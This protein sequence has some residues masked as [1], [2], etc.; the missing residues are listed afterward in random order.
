MTLAREAAEALRAFGVE[1]AAAPVRLRRGALNR[2]Y[3][4]ETTGGRMFLRRHRD[5]LSLA[6]VAHEHE[7]IR[8]AGERGLPVVMPLP[9]ASGT[10]VIDVAGARWSLFPWVEGRQLVRGRISLAAAYALGDLNG[11]VHAV[12]AGYPAQ[13]EASRI[14]WDT[15]DS[16]TA[17]RGLEAA[18]V[19]QGGAA[20]VLDGVRFRLRLLEQA[21]E[22]GDFDALPIQL[23]HG[24]FH[25]RQ[26]IFGPANE[27]RALTD[28]EM[29]WPLP[30]AWEVIRS[31]VFSKLHTGPGLEAYVAGYA[32]HVTAGAEEWAL[33][34][35]LWWQSRIHETWALRRYYLEGDRRVTPFVL[36]GLRH[37]RALAE[38]GYRPRLAARLASAGAGGAQASRPRPPR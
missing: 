17:L 9:T 3:R 1:A 25:D 20:E 34:L 29:A 26:V 31:L 16:R 27:V 13:G 36:D 33:G 28:W 18:I 12:L 37:V 14:T 10:S 15:K 38:P 5:G 4:V 32:R 19:A 35:E 22:P 11:R 2:N 6:A 8:W 30:R 24:D 23:C 7:I 21:R